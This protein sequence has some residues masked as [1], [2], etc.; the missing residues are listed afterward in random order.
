MSLFLKSN[1]DGQP[2][3]RNIN[4]CVALDISGSMNSGLSHS[5]PSEKTRLMLARDAILMLFEKL[6]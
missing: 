3:T 4:V 5:K 2:R 6:K 1:K